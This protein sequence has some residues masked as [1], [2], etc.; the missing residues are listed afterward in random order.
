MIDDV[1][2]ANG[3]ALKKACE[4]SNDAWWIMPEMS[5]WARERWGGIWWDC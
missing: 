2:D 3:I 1:V 5:R 4:E